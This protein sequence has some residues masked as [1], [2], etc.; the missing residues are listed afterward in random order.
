M[1]IELTYDED[2]ELNAEEILG[3]IKLSKDRQAIE[4]D[5]TYLDSW[6]IA[7]IEGLHKIEG[8][9][10]V[11]LDLIEESASLEMER[12]NEL[13]VIKYKTQKVVLDGVEELRAALKE[14][15]Q[16]MILKFR[17]DENFGQNNLLKQV[18][19]FAAS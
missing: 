2:F 7:L 11:L 1:Y 5:N 16:S 17:S 19:A 8:N 3:K 4:E 18:S 15:A 12:S 10:R 9:G 13:L 14:S 6:I